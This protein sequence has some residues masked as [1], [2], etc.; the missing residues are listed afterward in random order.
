MSVIIKTTSDYSTHWIYI[1]L[2]LEDLVNGRA[3]IYCILVIDSSYRNVLQFT[4]EDSN[5]ILHKYFT[6]KL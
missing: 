3:V 2:G 4:T 6:V 1:G 5:F